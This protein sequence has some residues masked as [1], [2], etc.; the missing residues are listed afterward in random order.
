ATGTEVGKTYITCGL[1]DALRR[2]GTPVSAL[3]P[4]ISGFDPAQAHT[5]DTGLIL[6]ALGKQVNEHS[7]AEISPWR[8]H[9]ALSPDMAA[10]REDRP[11]NLDALIAVCA[12]AA[13]N[14]R[15]TFIEGAGGIMSPLAPRFTNL[16]LIDA[17]DAHVLL[18]AGT[19]L[20][21]ISH[22]LTACE[23]LK[24]R[25]RDPWTIIFSES[26]Q[27]PVPPAETA[28]SLA[29]FTDVPIIVVNRNGEV[30]SELLSLLLR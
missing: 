15:V 27:S 14:D 25:G 28:R 6:R 7:V 26:P 17:I 16:D 22:T 8:Y 4:I 18:V 9:A 3:K 19:Y 10:A 5:S 24:V 29:R 30:P 23:A 13:N 11:I 21:T 20:G 1:I 12:S 2:R